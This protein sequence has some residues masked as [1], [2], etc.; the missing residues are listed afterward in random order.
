M[1]TNIQNYEYSPSSAIHGMVFDPKEEYL[2]SADMWGDKVW[3]H[4]KDGRTGKVECVGSVDVP[5][6][7]DH[8][9]WVE[10]HPKG[11]YLYVLMEAA[12]YLAVYTI[13]PGSHMPVFT[14]MTY[15]L[16]PQG[17]QNTP[18]VSSTGLG[19]G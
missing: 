11:G 9:R 4:R 3:A 13:D 12:N 8:P 18:S 1:D 7:G 16:I 6:P 17:K 2:Y 10:M 5:K 19:S 15:P 14:G